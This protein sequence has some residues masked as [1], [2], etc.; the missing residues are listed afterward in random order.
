M[1]KT[2]NFELPESQGKSF[3]KLLDAT[4]KILNKMER[5]SPERDTRLDKMHKEFQEQL[6]ETKKM[7]EQTSQRM[8]KWGLPLEK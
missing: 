7:M 6:A 3:E 2:I 4:L 1:E 5:N 8:A